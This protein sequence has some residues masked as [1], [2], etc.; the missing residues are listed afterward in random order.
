MSTA[1]T[2]EV[3]QQAAQFGLKLGFEPPDTLTFQ[4]AKR[5]PMEFAITLQAHKP[6]LL[7]LLRLPFVMAYSKTLED[8]VFFCADDD[9]RTALIE[10]GADSWSIYTRDELRILCEQNRIAPLT[11]AELA[12]LYEIKRT[13]WGTIAEP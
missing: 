4:P 1:A 7:T 3:L 9:T 6:Q 10:A 8:T 12:K 13:F 2:I 5:C 11:Q